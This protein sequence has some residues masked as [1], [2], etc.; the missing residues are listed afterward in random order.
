M[1]GAYVEALRLSLGSPAG[2]RRHRLRSGRLGP[3]HAGR[4]GRPVRDLPVL[5][6]GHGRCL[7][8][9]PGHA[10][11]PVRQPGQGSPHDGTALFQ[12][13]QPVQRFRVVRGGAG[14]PRRSGVEIGIL[15][16]RS[17]GRAPGC[18]PEPANRGLTNWR[19]P[20]VLLHSVE[21]EGRWDPGQCIRV[22]DARQDIRGPPPVD[23]SLR[24]L[25]RAPRLGR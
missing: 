8:R 6:S 17:L 16:R 25:G 13:P 11:R 12:L 21:H 18:R 14:T 1:R 2:S 3:H 5:Q 7:D 4:A 19:A 23:R 20:S 15:V 22:R 24:V 10:W 9:A